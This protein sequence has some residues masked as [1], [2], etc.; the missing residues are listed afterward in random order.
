MCRS[1]CISWLGVELSCRPEGGF[2]WRLLKGALGG[3]VCLFLLGFRQPQFSADGIVARFD[4]SFD[5]SSQV[6]ILKSVR[7]SKDGDVLITET[8]V[9]YQILDD[10]ARSLVRYLGTGKLA[11]FTLLMIQR[12]GEE[13]QFYRFDP[14]VGRVI[15]LAGEEL[16]GTLP[17]SDWNFED[18]LDDDKEDLTHKFLGT[19]TVS[20]IPCSQIETR[21][22]DRRQQSMSNYEKRH[23]YFAK[24]DG[25]LVMIEFYDRKDRMYK[26]LRAAAHSAVLEGNPTQIRHRRFEIVNHLTDTVTI[27]VVVA[28]EYDVPLPRNVFAVEN[29]GKWTGEFEDAVLAFLP[30]SEVWNEH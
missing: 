30:G 21:Y 24:D 1:R 14:A 22:A 18:M 17:E 9:I 15:E 26:T 28:S 25:R 5:V 29:L 4:A 2:R 3:L 19:Q 10:G 23:F 27:A 12:K 20:G 7:V 13:Q 11:G 6:E 8:L 16:R